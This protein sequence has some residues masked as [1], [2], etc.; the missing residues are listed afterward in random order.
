MSSEGFVSAP[1]PALSGSVELSQ[2]WWAGTGT[3]LSLSLS[4]PAQPLHKAPGALMHI[5]ACEP[6]L[7]DGRWSGEVDAW[8]PPSRLMPL[9]MGHVG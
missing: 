7:A 6:S 2:S 1:V 3:G 5:E 9:V 4:G 8:R